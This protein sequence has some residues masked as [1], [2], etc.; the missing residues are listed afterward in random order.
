M[1]QQFFVDF[2]L[3][4]SEFVIFLKFELM[5]LMK[6][7]IYTHTHKLYNLIDSIT[8]DQINEKWNLIIW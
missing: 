4:L 8:C 3:I 7:T 2:L 5:L 1:I 6:Y